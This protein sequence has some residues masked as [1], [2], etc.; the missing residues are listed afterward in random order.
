MAMMVVV[1]PAGLDDPGDPPFTLPEPL[2]PG[3][4]NPTVSRTS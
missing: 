2:L 4:S 3:A 1:M